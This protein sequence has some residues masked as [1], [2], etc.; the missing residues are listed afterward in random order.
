M[1]NNFNH[2]RSS[3]EDVEMADASSTGVVQQTEAE[4][5]GY[6]ECAPEP[7]RGSM[8]AVEETQRR[9]SIKAVMAD[10]TLSPMAKRL[11]IQYLMD[12]RRTSITNSVCSSVNDYSSDN[13][14]EHRMNNGTSTNGCTARRNGSISQRTTNTTNNHH[15]LQRTPSQDYAAAMYGYGDAAPDAAFDD[16][17]QEGGAAGGG[18]ICNDSTRRAERQRPACHHYDRKCT[19]IAPCCGAAFGCRICHDECPAL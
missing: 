3:E 14:A 7:R 11:S 16:Q 19:M 4:E 1:E 13:N 5:M 10:S 2:H 17:Q 12:G 8:T 9:A 6:E 18:V 15:H